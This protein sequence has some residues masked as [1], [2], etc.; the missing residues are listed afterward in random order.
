MV[1]INNSFAVNYLIMLAILVPRF[2]LVLSWFYRQQEG[3]L[4][5]KIAM[6]YRSLRLR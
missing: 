3:V 2:L 4:K 5:P 6:D 1:V